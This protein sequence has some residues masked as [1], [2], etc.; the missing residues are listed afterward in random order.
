MT[1]RPVTPICAVPVVGVAESSHADSLSLFGCGHRQIQKGGASS[2]A[3]NSR[4]SSVSHGTASA[5]VGTHQHRRG[6]RRRRRRRRARLLAAP[7]RRRTRSTVVGPPAASAPRGVCAAAQ[8]TS[9]R[10]RGV[11][12]VRA[13]RGVVGEQ[14]DEQAH[15][16]ERVRAADEARE[17]GVHRGEHLEHQVV[18]GPKV[19]ALVRQDRRH[20]VVRQR[21]QRAL[22]DHDAAAHAGQAVG[23]R[24]RDVA[25]CAA[26]LAAIGRVG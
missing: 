18:P 7:P 2:R 15:R 19:R 4:C 24:L 17:R 8:A 22:A 1:A 12:P 9:A 3:M 25:G 10:A 14:L 13:H 23:Q 6:G 11:G 20:L 5:T 26:P 21:V 16:V